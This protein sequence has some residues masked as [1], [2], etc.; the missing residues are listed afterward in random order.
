MSRDAHSDAS[1]RDDMPGLPSPAA[2]TNPFAGYE[3]G[4]ATGLDHALHRA[5]DRRLARFLS[6]DPLGI[7]AAQLA[8]PQTLNLQRKTGYGFGIRIVR[9]II[10]LP[11]RRNSSAPCKSGAMLRPLAPSRKCWWKAATQRWGNGSDALHRIARSR[12][13]AR[14]PGR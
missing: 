9:L 7:G 8:D 12:G 3:R 4:A 11:D 5:Y 14:A 6:A 10:T 1:V 2:D 13:G